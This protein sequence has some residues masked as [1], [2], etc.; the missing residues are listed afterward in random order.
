MD[1]GPRQSWR[2]RGL[3]IEW[4]KDAAAGRGGDTGGSDRE[5]WPAAA[6][7][8]IRRAIQPGLQDNAA[9]ARMGEVQPVGIAAAPNG[10]RTWHAYERWSAFRSSLVLSDPSDSEMGGHPLRRGTVIATLSQ[11]ICTS[12]AESARGTIERA[13]GVLL[14]G[15]VG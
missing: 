1:R 9:R 8:I 7:A 12:F 4:P 11:E 5:W 15:E 6:A 2:V 14:E 13:R 3:V 10:P